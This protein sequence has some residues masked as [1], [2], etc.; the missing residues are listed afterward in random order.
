MSKRLAAAKK[1]LRKDLGQTDRLFVE[2]SYVEPSSPEEKKRMDDYKLLLDEGYVV[3]HAE[4]S[5]RDLA[6]RDSNG[7]VLLHLWNYRVTSKGLSENHTVLQKAYMNVAQNIPT[8][9]V[10]VL[11][12]LLIGWLAQR[13]GIKL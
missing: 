9:I 11:S 1:R 3:L 2:V 4:Q 5:L 6:K 13:L 8:I 12:G 10:S 7:K